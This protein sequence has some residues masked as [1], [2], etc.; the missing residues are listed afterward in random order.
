[1]LKIKAREIPFLLKIM[2]AALLIAGWGAAFSGAVPAAAA[3]FKHLAL[4][5]ALLCCGAGLLAILVL[6]VICGRFYC[7][8]IC[9][10]GIIQDIL[11][12]VMRRKNVSCSGGRKVRMVI[13]GVCAGMMAAGSAAGVMWFDPY[14]NA[15]RMSWAL[16]LC[17]V[18]TVFI[19]G[20]I[21]FFRPRGF[22]N[23][24]CPAGTLL[25]TV[26]YFPVLQL[27][28]NGNCIKCAKCAKSCPAGCIDITRWQIDQ[29]RCLRCMKCMAV[30]P[31]EKSGISFCKLRRENINLSRRQLLVNTG[32]FLAAA[33]AGAAV[34]KS[35][36]LKVLSRLPGSPI[37]PP[38]AGNLRRFSA[39]CTGCQLCVKNC[40]AQIIV[41]APGGVGTVSLDMS[42]GSCKFKCH[43]CSSICPSGAIKRLPRA[44]KQKTKIAE[45]AVL[46]GKCVGCGEC[47]SVCPRKAVSIP[48]DIA[49]IDNSKCTGCG[50]CA[51]V[52]PVQAI[53]IS[54]IPEQ[55]T[56]R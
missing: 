2:L 47:E 52:C 20:V 17:S 34:V 41:P 10:L 46:A 38:G 5:P 9:P 14:S 43:R 16:P 12:G 3:L 56:L 31:A 15:G 28:F 11:R 30:C 55:I 36:V 6:T 19:A 37:L 21:V 53:K 50:K 45:A 24:I 25:E 4:L 51:R 32:I 42:R 8:C 39:K 22:C 49:V 23:H 29:S 40:P 35:G 18:L 13:S 54:G 7:A 44:E 26:S 33:A 27:N 1:M 48:Q